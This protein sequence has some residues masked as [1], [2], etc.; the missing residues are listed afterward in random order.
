[1]ESVGDGGAIILDPS[2]DEAYSG[3]VNEVQWMMWVTFKKA[4]LMWHRL[5]MACGWVFCGCNVH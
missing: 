4:T 5:E 3:R 1:M 2:F